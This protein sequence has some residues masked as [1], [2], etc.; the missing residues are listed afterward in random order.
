MLTRTSCYLCTMRQ[1][2]THIAIT[3]LLFAG[4]ACSGTVGRYADMR[5]EDSIAAIKTRCWAPRTLVGG[6]RDSVTR[7]MDSLVR[8]LRLKTGLDSAS[9]FTVTPG[10]VRVTDADGTSYPRTTP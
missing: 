6:G 7:A 8:T 1:I 10:Y 9:F 2:I 5:T 3:T 4:A